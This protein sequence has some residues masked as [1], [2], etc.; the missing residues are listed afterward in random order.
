M[1]YDTQQDEFG[2]PPERK[3]GFSM[4]SLLISWGIVKT[5]D[6]AQKVWVGV[7]VVALLVTAYM[8]YSMF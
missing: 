3:E 7:I 8:I 5:P 1:S 6:Q 2:K 4:T